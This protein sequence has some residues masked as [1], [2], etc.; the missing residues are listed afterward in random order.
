MKQ[1]YVHTITVNIDNNE[2]R[3]QYKRLIES[4]DSAEVVFIDLNDK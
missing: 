1:E 3:E 4:L 2:A